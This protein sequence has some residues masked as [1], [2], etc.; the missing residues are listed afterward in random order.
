MVDLFGMVGPVKQY[1]VALPNRMPKSQITWQLLGQVIQSY[2]PFDE[3]ERLHRS[4]V[5]HPFE[6]QAWRIYI[7][8][9][10]IFDWGS[11]CCC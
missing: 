9:S 1:Y 7:T 3:Y 4:A 2:M 8:A 11:S 6:S 10:L 5:K